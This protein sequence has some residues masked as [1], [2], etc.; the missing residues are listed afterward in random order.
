[1]Q[2]ETIKLVLGAQQVPANGLQF[3]ASSGGA[4]HGVDLPAPHA[5]VEASALGIADDACD[6]EREQAEHEQ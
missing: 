4:L 1:M 6:P 2:G 5:L 3:H